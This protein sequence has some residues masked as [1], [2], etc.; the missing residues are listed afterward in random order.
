MHICTNFA[1]KFREF[2]GPLKWVP[3]HQVILALGFKQR[4]N[5]FEGG[6]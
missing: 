3:G 4:E 6:Q 2:L 1:Y 5:P